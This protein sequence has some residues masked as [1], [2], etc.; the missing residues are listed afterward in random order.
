[1]RNSSTEEQHGHRHRTVVGTGLLALDVVMSDSPTVPSRVQAGGTCGN[2]ITALAY[3]GWTAYPVA[4]IGKDAAMTRICQDLER[5]G[6]KLDFVHRNEDDET[7]VIAQHIKRTE[8]GISHTFAWRCPM[9]GADL[10]RYRPI[11]LTELETALPNL[12]TAEVFFLDRVSAAAIKLAAHYRRSG[13]LVVFEPSGIGDPRLFGEVVKAAHLVKFSRERIEDF[14]FEMEGD[15]PKL[16]IETCGA[17]GLQFLLQGPGVRARRW[18]E[19]PAIRAPHTV[20]TA[21]CGDWC[22]AGII[23]TLIENPGTNHDLSEELV[24]GAIRYGQALAA[25]NCGFE[26]ARG[27]MYDATRREFELMVAALLA[28]RIPDQRKASRKVRDETL[29]AAFACAACPEEEPVRVRRLGTS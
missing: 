21:G 7:P 28:G 22:I 8:G 9:C 17:D 4:R 10:P 1:M 11:R 20:D 26:G 24:I 13:A 6:V 16:F 15:E 5:W 27:G 19:M 23:H 14:D 12:P 29:S 25:W 18:K 2:V 3:L